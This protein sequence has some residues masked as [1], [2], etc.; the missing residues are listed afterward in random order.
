L[1]VKPAAE[2]AELV[3]DHLSRGSRIDPAIAAVANGLAD[4]GSAFLDA[5][6][7]SG[8]WGRILANL[9]TGA[10]QIRIGLEML[11]GQPGFEGLVQFVER[12]R[13]FA[14]TMIDEVIRLQAGE[15]TPV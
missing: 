11:R 13:S 1:R 12:Q 6:D 4:I 10:E 9:R 5:Q 7:E 14:S 2:L 15:S 3:N 8:N